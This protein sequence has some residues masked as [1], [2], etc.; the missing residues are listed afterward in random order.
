M[1]LR[2]SCDGTPDHSS[3]ASHALRASTMPPSHRFW[4]QNRTL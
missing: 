3:V 4:L 1:N 2:L